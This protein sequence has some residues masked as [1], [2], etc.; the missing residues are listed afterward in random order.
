MLRSAI[1][2]G[3]A[4]VMAL[5]LSACSGQ[6]E[7]PSAAPPS[8]AGPPQQT[9]AATP[10]TPLDLSQFTPAPAGVIDEH[11]GETIQPQPAPTWDA[12][13][14]TAATDAAQTAMTAFARPTLD[15]DTWWSDLSPLLTQQAQQDY[16][17]VDPANVPASIVTGP[18]VLVD[19]TSAYVALVEVPTDAGT[20]TLVLTRDSAAAPWLT[21]RF[22]P[23]AE[24][25]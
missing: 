10:A 11:T 5:T 25:Q 15:Y 1:R 18:G 19:E 22:T 8:P 20:Y 24:A 16:S 6:G 14:Q 13:A 3:I 7:S 23:P 12:A 17:Y 2:A 21:S 4:T 9:P